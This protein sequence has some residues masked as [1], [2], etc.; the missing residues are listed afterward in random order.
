ML[1]YNKPITGQRGIP[2]QS[3]DASNNIL[4]YECTVV[5]AAKLQS[6]PLGFHT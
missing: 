4:S 3:S 2:W 5:S 6:A 1:S